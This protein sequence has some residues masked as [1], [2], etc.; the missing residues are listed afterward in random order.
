MDSALLFRALADDTRRRIVLLL[1]RHRYCVSA[2]AK[3]LGISESAVSQHLKVLKEAMLL[4]GERHGYYM[5]YD[6]DRE[7]LRALARELDT[8]A[9]TK[10]PAPEVSADHPQEHRCCSE[11]V[12][13]LCHGAANARTL[14]M[15]PVDASEES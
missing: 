7:R 2:L 11:T 6:I 15:A 5:H 8:L 9:D 4:C 14:P 3:E 13:R 10:R 12:R 1:L